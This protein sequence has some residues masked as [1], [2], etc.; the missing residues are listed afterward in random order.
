MTWMMNLDDKYRLIESSIFTKDTFNGFI[1]RVK[2]IDSALVIK[3]NKEIEGD[4]DEI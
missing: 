1:E 4:K 2:M 3:Y